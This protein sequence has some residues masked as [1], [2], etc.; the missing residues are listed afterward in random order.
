M[1][2]RDQL[3]RQ[4]QQLVPL[5]P[6]EPADPATFGGGEDRGEF[7]QFMRA[8]KAELLEK[9]VFGRQTGEHLG[10]R[11]GDLT[12]GLDKVVGQPELVEHAAH[13]N[14]VGE[15]VELEGGADR[16]PEQQVLGDRGVRVVALGVVGLDEVRDALGDEP[17]LQGAARFEE[18]L[19]EFGLR[20]RI[21]PAAQPET[22]DV[23]LE[24]EAPQ[25]FGNT[26]GQLRGAGDAG[27][28]V[29]DPVGLQI[30]IDVA[31]AARLVELS[32]ALPGER[33]VVFGRPQ[34]NVPQREQQIVPQ[35]A[36]KEIRHRGGIADAAADHGYRQ[37]GKIEP[38]HRDAAARRPGEAREQ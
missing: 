28:P 8:D 31:G 20:R 36:G 3:E 37:F 26:F 18:A 15:R 27:A 35:G 1:P 25:D 10:H 11:R 22:V 19:G 24:I 4:G 7:R 6:V 33:L 29:I 13:M 38:A 21:E 12:P 14:I 2:R 5:L 30:E 32:L 17:L 16:R 34:R 9:F 23:L